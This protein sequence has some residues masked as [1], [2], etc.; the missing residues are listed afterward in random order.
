MIRDLLI[1]K[2]CSLGTGRCSGVL[3]DKIYTSDACVL[4]EAPTIKYVKKHANV[5]KRTRD[6][7]VSE[8][9]QRYD[10]RMQEVAN[11]QLV[12][13]DK[14]QDPQLNAFKSSLIRSKAENLL[15][16]IQQLNRQPK[17]L[18]QLTSESFFE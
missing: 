12:R 14:H 15:M 4:R 11:A 9:T 3:N 10:Q 1:K 2:Y 5:Q 7:Y 18:N 13:S 16:Q 8:Y 6:R 17:L